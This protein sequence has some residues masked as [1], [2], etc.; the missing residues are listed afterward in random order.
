MAAL[1]AG[2]QDMAWD[3]GRGLLWTVSI[4][5]W[6]GTL[7]SIDP[8]TQAVRHWSLPSIPALKFRS[9]SGSTRSIAVDAEGGIWFEASGYDLYRFDPAAER[10]KAVHLDVKT[11]HWR[12]FGSFVLAIVPYGD[13]VLVARRGVPILYRYD[14]TMR[15]VG[16]VPLPDQ[17]VQSLEV[18]RAGSNLVIRGDKWLGLFD[19]HG[20]RIR[21]LL[22]A[23]A[24]SALG[25]PAATSDDRRRAAIWQ[26]DH[27]VLLDGNGREVGTVQPLFDPVTHPNVYP[28]TDFSPAV[29]YATDWHGRWWYVVDGFA[30]QVNAP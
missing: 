10:F 17:Y 26:G 21:Q 13:G 2:S 5:D 1:P 28:R 18:T 6:H 24:P 9:A 22:Y 30:V 16:S 27:L 19:I 4:A 7:T 12:G 11:G 23:P 20:N 29:A 14:A 8:A 3:A 15:V 25:L